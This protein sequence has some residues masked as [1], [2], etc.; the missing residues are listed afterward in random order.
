[1][2]TIDILVNKLPGVGTTQRIQDRDT[3]DYPVMNTNVKGAS[4]SH[5]KE[6]L[7]SGMIARRPELRPAV[8]PVGA[9]STS[10]RWAG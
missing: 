7:A 5:N 8:L 6:V 9:S 1:M 3:E 10:R 4:L 2:G